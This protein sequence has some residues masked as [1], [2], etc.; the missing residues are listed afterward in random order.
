M[1]AGP[2]ASGGGA[3]RIEGVGR[4][5]RSRDGERA[6]A[7]IDEEKSDGWGRRGEALRFYTGGTL[8]S[9]LYPRPGTKGHLVPT[10]G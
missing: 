2:P 6:A 7:E 10:G 3:G 8:L 9:R 1:S 4:R 5:R